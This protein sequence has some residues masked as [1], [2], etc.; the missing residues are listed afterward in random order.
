MFVDM[1]VIF[2]FSVSNE[3]SSKNENVKVP[4]VQITFNVRYVKYISLNSASSE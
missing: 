1:L 4:T 2:V 3:S